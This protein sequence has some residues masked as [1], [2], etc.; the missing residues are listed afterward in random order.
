MKQKK[1]KLTNET[2]TYNGKVLHRIEALKDFWD[3]KKGE[4]GGWIEKE[5]NLSQENSCWVADYAMVY[6]KARIIDNAFVFA[7]AKVSGNALISGDALISGGA[8]VHGDALISGNAWIFGDAE[9]SGN[10]FISGDAWIYKK[11][12]ITGGYF[13]HTTKRLNK[14]VIVQTSHPEERTLAYEPKIKAEKINSL[15][16]MEKENKKYKLTD[17]TKISEDG[18]MLHRIQ[19]LKSFG[20]VKKGELGGWIEKEENLSQDGNCWVGGEAMVYDNAR[21]INDAQ[22]F[23]NAKVGGEALIRNKAQVFGKSWIFDEALISDNAKVFGNPDAKVFGKAVVVCGNA[24]IKG[25]AQVSGRAK[26]FDMVS[27]YD[28]A[29]VSGRCWIFDH[30]DICGDAIVCGYTSIFGT[31]E[32]SDKIKITGGKFYFTLPKKKKIVKVK[33][34]I[35]KDKITFAYNPKI[36]KY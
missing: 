16:F 7:C 1:Y 26:I 25:N 31:V 34:S 6:G 20:N 19:A 11:I 33:T 23:E 2:K 14:I 32:I 15:K 27:V 9:V 21:V 5:E 36:K 29:K 4:K 3:I 24:R 18:I 8:W 28:N 22:V 35:K 12:K 17:E 30:V 10:A 13:F